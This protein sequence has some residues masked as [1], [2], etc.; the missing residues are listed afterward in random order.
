M[1]GYLRGLHTWSIVI[2]YFFCVVLLIPLAHFGHTITARRFWPIFFGRLNGNASL[3]F[4][5]LKIFELNTRKI[6]EGSSMHFE[7]EIIDCGF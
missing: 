7:L 1:F 4:N 6:I 2:S 5:V 3:L